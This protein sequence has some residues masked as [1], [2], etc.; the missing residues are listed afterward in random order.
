MKHE[1]GSILLYHAGF[2][3]IRDPDIRHGRKNADFGQGFY[4]SPDRDFS[5]RWAKERKGC[6]TIV[7][8]YEL[9][10]DGLQI[11]RFERKADWYDY[12]YAN[13]HGQPDSLNC[14][15]VM[16]PIANDTLF[17]VLG[18]ITS[19][20]LP[21]EQ[22][23][24]LLQIGPEY[25]Q[26]AIKTDRAASQLHW[27]S[28]RMMSPDELARSQEMLKVEEEKYQQLFAEKMQEIEADIC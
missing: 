21:K 5:E 15:L 13:R 8:T 14:D 4:L 1:K 7:N 18:I 22:S 11:K 20:L 19:G 27:L 12:I 17:D 10:T 26:V 23:L 3:E 24:K 6:Q 2:E 9:R 25:R 28:S 16:G